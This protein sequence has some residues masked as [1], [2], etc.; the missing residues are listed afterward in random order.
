LNGK[1]V[2]KGQISSQ[3]T[4]INTSKLP[5]SAYFLDVLNPENEKVQS[6]KILKK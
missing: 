2:D 3:Q 1:L 4:R 5:I 6:F